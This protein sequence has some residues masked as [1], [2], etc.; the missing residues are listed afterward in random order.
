MKFAELYT[1]QVFEAGPHLLTEDEALGFA[2]QYDPQWFHT[3]AAAAA[4]GPYGGL[5]A[6]GWQ[7]CAIATRLMVDAVLHD[8]ESFSSP[9][10]EQLRWLQ[11]VR[12]GDR[13]WLRAQ[14][15]HKG[16]RA[17]KAHVGEVRWRWQLSKQG[18]VPVLDMQVSNLFLLRSASR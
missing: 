12:P 10:V 8:A 5:V 2:R 6:S 13:L 17:G 15:L 4:A 14:V 11:P 9:G 3:D 16:Q 1:G 7:S 18:G